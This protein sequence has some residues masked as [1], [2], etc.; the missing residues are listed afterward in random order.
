MVGR[1]TS[2]RFSPDLLP[3]HLLVARS[4]PDGVPRVDG[5]RLWRKTTM[6]IGHPETAFE[7]LPCRRSLP[8]IRPVVR[9]VIPK[10]RQALADNRG[11]ILWTHRPT[12]ARQLR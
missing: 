3:D 4:C 12:R 8:S 5:V 7:R 10:S 6:L 2:I 9:H 11:A 1:N